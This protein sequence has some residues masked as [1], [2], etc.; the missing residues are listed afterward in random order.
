[1]KRLSVTIVLLGYCALA[2]CQ[3]N[4]STCEGVIELGVFPICDGTVYTNEGATP[5]D[6]SFDNE[7][8]CFVENPPSNDV[9][10][11]FVT[12]GE[13]KEI[14][15]TIDGVGNDGIRNI[16]AAL[17]RGVCAVNS[18]ALRSCAV[19]E[20]GEQQL[21]IDASDLTPNAQY[22]LRVD[23]FGGDAN[24][25]EFTV[26][27]EEKS[28]DFN[29]SD[30][31]T[32]LCRGRLY[33]S[34]GP[35][36]NYGDNEN[37][38]FTICPSDF[39]R[40]VNLDMA[41][42]NI[43]Q[44]TAAVGDQII[45]Y[46]GPDTR[47]PIIS[48]LGPDENFG[49]AHGGGGSCYNVQADD[50]LT[51]QFISD[52]SVNFE[53]FEANWECTVQPCTTDKQI[54]ISG[55]LTKEDIE[56]AI[57]TPLSRVKIDTIICHEG[58]LGTF[59]GG[60]E[61]DLGLNSGL[62]L[63]TGSPFSVI[64]PN[65]SDKIST[66]N[67][68]EG[69]NDLDILSQL[70]GDGSTS[71]D[72]CVVEMEVEVFSN[73]LTFEYI[74]GSEEYPEFVGEN[75]NDIFAL[76]IS[77]PGIDGI[78]EI[79]NQKNLAI[80]PNQEF[81]Q[82]NSVNH[83]SN[84]E[85]YRNNTFGQS[86]EYDG[87]TSGLGS[88]K[89]LTASTEV[90]PCNTYRLKLAIADRGDFAFDS[91]VFIAEISSGA[92]TIALEVER[93][94][95]NIVEK[96][97]G[98]EDE[99]SVTLNRPLSTDV[100]FTT[101]I[102]GSAT[103]G[104]DYQLNLP[105]EITFLAGETIKTYPIIPISDDLVEGTEEIIIKLINETECGT[106]TLSELV[107]EIDDEV[108]VEIDRAQDTLQ[109]CLATEVQISASGARE[110]TWSPINNI[111]DPFSPN[112]ILQLEEDGWLFV[113]GTLGNTEFAECTATDSIFI[114][115][116]NPITQ[117]V[118]LGKENFCKGEAL[119]LNVNTNEETFALEWITALGEIIEQDNGTILNIS[120]VGE[121][122]KIFVQQTTGECITTDSLTINVDDFFFPVLN[123]TD[124]TV[125]QSDAVE[126]VPFVIPSST[127][128]TWSPSDF[129]SATNIANPIAI[130]ERDQTYTL[131]AVSENGFCS[132]DTSISIK[133]AQNEIN[134]ITEGPIKICE[135]E[136]IDISAEVTSTSSNPIVSWTIDQN[137][138]S[139]EGI[140]FNRSISTEGFLTAIVS[141]GGCVNADSIFIEVEALPDLD[142]LTLPDRNS[143]CA[144]EIVTLI[145]EDFPNTF[146]PDISF[147]WLDVEGSNT[148]LNYA[149]RTEESRYF[150]RKT[151]NGL[152]E[153]LDSI[154]VIVDDLDASL[155]ITEATICSGDTL[156][157]QIISSGVDE[158]IWSPNICETTNCE[159][160]FLEL[161]FS[162]DFT[163]VVKSGN[164]R[165]TLDLSVKVIDYDLNIVEVEETV[166]LG[167]EMTFVAELDIEYDGRYFWF[168]NDELL[169]ETSNTLM[170][171]IISDTTKVQVGIDLPSC[172]DSA[173]FIFA[174]IPEIVF[175]DA[176][177]PTGDVLNQTFTY[178]AII[179]NNGFETAFIN[180]ETF[181]IF[182]RWGQQVFSC[183]DQTCLDDGWDGR[184]NGREAPAAVYAYIFKGA[185]PNGD[186]IIR[187]GNVTLIR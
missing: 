62:L 95:D 26:C 98:N 21:S 14:V 161:D 107:V 130:P 125:C 61:T 150:V 171:Q 144:G 153:S 47:S 91:G 138:T 37:Y 11:G 75:F 140:R 18:I 74:F 67:G 70:N 106:V 182:N 35:D 28:I 139:A 152:C 164:C 174:S 32:T 27:I 78:P 108:Q 85:F 80:L 42:F 44:K 137:P 110:Y 132:V 57:S 13:R 56:E 79:D 172:G 48:V 19:S 184:I 97:S 115:T 29:I 173:L 89:S 136:E 15:I 117:I 16:Q 187:K 103:L 93:S 146:F 176:F 99:I 127:S 178:A 6:I 51:I 155:N 38:T 73:E 34:G 76:L 36:G 183:D 160:V 134:I 81:V 60:D 31:T 180:V 33:D 10:F 12:S 43:E 86:I 114:Q 113:K 111:S 143:F 135:G 94:S 126:I 1:M 9:W 104:T 23:N 147:E 40:C 186:E 118:E 124:T 65:I 25:G 84:W 163:A 121:D 165:D 5:F 58:A 49:T 133:V 46:N 177:I 154:F 54:K 116:I 77:G 7:P 158:V 149:F 101:I 83:L 168:I 181:E 128:Y 59:N 100:S 55:E 122:Q 72:A 53:G 39:H 179:E 22:Y 169:D 50:C 162:Q 3:P 151:V 166:P 2:W 185:L 112:P 87:L 41:F 88:K 102:E 159:T 17:Y 64:G 20:A 71:N 4:N 66:N 167:T 24:E 45:F 90:L 119:Q 141:D 96:C 129:L 82:I 120:T 142:I 175:P 157:L 69:D 30:E 131:T 92:P 52:R 63:T 123:F 156:P 8:A 68:F 145:S 148:G 170:Y 109:T 105:A